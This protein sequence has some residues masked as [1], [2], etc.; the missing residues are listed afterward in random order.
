MAIEQ[1]YLDEFGYFGDRIYFDCSTM[2]MRPQ[3]TVNF[4]EQWLET[5]NSSLG[6]DVTVK[7]ETLRKKARETIAAFIHG[8]PAD[9][10]FTRNTTEGNNLLSQGYPLEPGDEV[11]VCNED[12]PAVYIP[13][14]FRQRDGISLSV[15]KSTDGIVSADDL[16]AHFTDKTRI[17]AV[18]MAQSSSG[19]VTDIKK[20]GKACRE[21]NILLSVD[22]VQAAGRL[23][24]DVSSMNVDVLATS[25]FKGLLGIMGAGFCWCRREVMDRIKPPVVSGNIN[26]DKYDLTPGFDSLPIPEFPAGARRM[27]TGTV[28]NLGIAIMAES[29]SMLN[30]IGIE[31]IAEHIRCLESYY[32]RRLMASGLDIHMLG[33]D[34]PSTWSGSVSFVYDPVLRQQLEEELANAKIHAAVRSYFRV[35]FHYYNT[36][37]QIDRLMIVLNKVLK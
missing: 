13:W 26:W 27:E 23:P 33:S 1:K 30:E 11:I 18:S 7:G 35:S 29:I 9:I 24:I 10:F 31:Q 36:A 14:S 22:A 25:S 21:R 19:Y 37:E 4:A 15:V 2:G 16:I 32:R 34:D 6:Q 28:N 8:D 20:L 3:R 17:V 12:F 5:F